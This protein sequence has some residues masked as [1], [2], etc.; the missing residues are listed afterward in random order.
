[1]PNLTNLFR[2]QVLM[3]KELFAILLWFQ[4]VCFFTNQ[5]KIKSLKKIIMGALK[6]S[7]LN[8]TIN[9]NSSQTSCQGEP[10]TPK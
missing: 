2:H 3:K 4:T 9:S 1:M 6:D 8:H 10:R 7:M 5:P